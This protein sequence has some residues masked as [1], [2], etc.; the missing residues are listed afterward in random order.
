M[1]PQRGRAVSSSQ[2]MVHGFAAPVLAVCGLS[3]S[4][5]TTLLEAAIPLLVQRGLAVAV[6]KHTSHGFEVDRQGKDS[7]RLFRAGATI[8]LRG[9]E[10]QFELRAAALSLEI[11]LARLSCDHDL[12]LVEGH[13]DTA[14]PKLWLGN[15]E[16]WD[17]PEGVTG[18]VSALAWN[19]DR[20]AAFLKYID[21]WLP[22]AWNARP[23]H[24]GLLLGGKSARMGRPKQALQF[25][26]RALG[27]IAAAALVAVPGIHRVAVLGG[28]VLPPVLSTWT[29]LPDAPEFAGPGAGMIAAHRWAPEAAWIVAA[30]DHPW[31]RARHVEWLAAQRQPGRWAVVPLQRDGH[32]CPTLALYEPQALE[33]MERLARA[34]R[35][36]N[37]DPSALLKLPRTA[38]LEPPPELA[39]GWTGVNTPEELRAEEVR[40]A[41]AD[42]PIDE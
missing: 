18:I 31:L 34:E 35:T 16:R 37:A 4:G 19:S 15:A 42:K 32:P 39:D 5:K 10:Q 17:A 12:L 28:G 33:A 3:G 13:K 40:L 22:M 26:G 14:L 8:S 29:Q 30:C 1:G 9:P 25:G 41:E 7:D 38:V 27:E 6:I 24:C 23:L 21:H 36:H 20:L 11:T 2:E